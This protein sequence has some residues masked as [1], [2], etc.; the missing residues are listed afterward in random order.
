VLTPW[1]SFAFL[2]AVYLTV[3]APEARPFART[4]GAAP[5]GA[6]VA[7]LRGPRSARLGLAHLG[8]PL[9]G[10]ARLTTAPVG[11]RRSTRPPR[12]AAVNRDLGRCGAGATASP[13]VAPRRA[14]FALILWAW[15]LAQY[16]YLIPPDLTIPRGGGPR[17][18]P[19]SSSSGPSWPGGS[20]FFSRR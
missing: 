2:A 13:R 3:E 8:A 5:L 1:P 15:A 20:C 12:L 7:V 10:R 4:S 19:S 17:A 16:P 18:S 14:R 9:M 6:A 11:P